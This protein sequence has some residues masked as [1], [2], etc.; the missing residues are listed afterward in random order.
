MESQTSFENVARGHANTIRG[1]SNQTSCA[2]SAARCD[3]QSP[4]HLSHTVT[5]T[6]SGSLVN[7][8]YMCCTGR[9]PRA[10]SPMVRASPSGPS[11][12][13]S[14]TSA[15]S[16]C[17]PSAVVR[18]ISR[19]LIVAPTH[20]CAPRHRLPLSKRMIWQDTVYGCDCACALALQHAAVAVHIAPHTLHGHRLSYD[21]RHKGS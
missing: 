16:P 15:G 17:Q 13:V 8:I 18:N 4:G 9:H 7:S 21:A 2:P 3:A 12:S 19:S 6:T 5:L 14:E 20:R 11:S 10:C 1:R